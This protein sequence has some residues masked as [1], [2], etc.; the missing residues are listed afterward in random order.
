MGI[1]DILA[2]AQTAQSAA[3]V[4]DSLDLVRRKKKKSRHFLETA[5]RNL[6]G[7]SLIKAQADISGGM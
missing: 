1:K 4:N 7:T 6:V 3:L 5:T 2:V